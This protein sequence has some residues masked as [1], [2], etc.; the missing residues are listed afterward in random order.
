MKWFLNSYR[1]FESV[2]AVIVSL[3]LAL[4]ILVAVIRLGADLYKLLIIDI[5]QPTEILFKDYQLLFGRIMTLLISLEFLTSSVNIVRFHN[6]RR[7]LE[8]VVLVASLAIA[9]KLIIYDYSHSQPYELFG[10]GFLFLCIGLFYF[11]LRY[12]RKQDPEKSAN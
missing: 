1:K 2:I 6:T 8:D 4:M 5:N 3:A 10:I 7:L 12:K 9:R 11:F